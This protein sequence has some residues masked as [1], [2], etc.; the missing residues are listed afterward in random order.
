MSSLNADSETTQIV[1]KY[2]S[3]VHLKKFPFKLLLY[4]CE[5]FVALLNGEEKMKIDFVCE[6]ITTNAIDANR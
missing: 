6:M 4:S 3:R 5:L 1:K 2:C